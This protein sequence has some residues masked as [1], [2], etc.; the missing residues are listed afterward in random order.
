ELQTW[1]SR[2]TLYIAHVKTTLLRQLDKSSNIKVFQYQNGAITSW[3]NSDNA[4]SSEL[5]IPSLLHTWTVLCKSSHLHSLHSM[6]CHHSVLLPPDICSLAWKHSCRVYNSVE[7]LPT[8][9]SVRA[10]TG[11]NF[12]QY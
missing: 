9:S 2:Q 5:C 3:D 12:C 1:W 8:T 4:N 10:E 11:E 7:K 6:L